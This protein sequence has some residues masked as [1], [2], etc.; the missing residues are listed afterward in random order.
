V[1][2]VP[3]R[4]V[5]ERVPMPGPLAGFLAAVRSINSSEAASLLQRGLGFVEPLLSRSVP[6]LAVHMAYDEEQETLNLELMTADRRL[7]FVVDREDVCWFYVESTGQ[8]RVDSGD[9]ATATDFA[10]LA[11]RMR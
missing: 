4:G 11:R 10:D 8:R 5:A 7:G 2:A 9:V 1:D 3:T 6:G